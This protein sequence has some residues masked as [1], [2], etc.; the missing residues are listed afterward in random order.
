MLNAKYLLKP[1]IAMVILQMVLLPIAPVL[2]QELNSTTSTTINTTEP[3]PAPIAL[4]VITSTA[5]IA[6]VAIEPVSQV[7]STV[8]LP[9]DSTMTVLDTSTPSST[10]ERLAE[11]QPLLQ[12]T[13]TIST[14]APER[15]PDYS[16]VMRRLNHLDKSKDVSSSEFERFVQSEKDRLDKTDLD[17]S[18]KSKYFDLLDK[19]L[20]R[21]KNEPPT[22]LEKIV[23]KTKE[24]FGLDSTSTISN[25]EPF[26]IPTK[27]AEFKF[28]TDQ[29]Y[30][31]QF[32]GAVNEH[33]TPRLMDMFNQVFKL[34]QASA[35]SQYLPTINDVKADNEVVINSE[36]QDLAIALNNNPVKILNYVRQNIAYEPYF[37]A[38]KGSLGCLKEKVCN[39]VDAS[40]LTISLLRAADIPA[41]YKKSVV[42]MN[43]EQ[44]K[45]LLGV[46]DLKT[47]YMAWAMNKVP[48]YTLSTT[49]FSGKAENY[50]FSN[51]TSLGLEWVFV[52]AFYDYDERG[53]NVDNILSFTGATTTADVQ[54]VLQ[55]Y[56]KK[57][58]IPIDAV[59]KTYN[60]TKNEIVHDTASFDTQNF[61]N[62]F[63][64]HN[65]ALSPLQKYAQDLKNTTGKDILN[66]SY[67]STNVGSTDGF[68]I[69]PPTLPYYTHTGEVGGSLIQPIAWSSLPDNYRA[70]VKISLFKDNDKSVVFEHTFF[71]NEINN[72][73]INLAYEGATDAD[74]QAIESYGGIHA[75]PAA[76]VNIK[77]YVLAG[78][79]RYDTNNTIKIGDK[80][81]LH[82]DYLQNGI[83]TYSD[84]KFS[85]AGNSEGIAVSLSKVQ[86]DPNLDT[87]SKILLQGNSALASKY[88]QHL[89]ETGNTLQKALDYR[90]NM[91]FSR[92][93]VTQNRILSTVDGTPTTFDF[94]GLTIDASSN[95]NDWSNRGIFNN[96]RKDFRLLWGEDASYYEGQIFDDITGLEG[97]STVKGLQYAYA[98]PADYTVYSITKTNESVID[99]LTLTDN[100]KQN[101]HTAVQAGDTVVTPNKAITDGAWTGIF[102]VAL[103]DD[104]TGT[105]AIGEQTQMNGGATNTVLVASVYTDIFDLKS[106]IIYIVEKLNSEYLFQE[107]DGH[108]IQCNILNTLKDD[109][110]KNYGWSSQYGQPCYKETKQYGNVSHTFIIA[111]N[112]TRFEGPGYNSY[113]V[114]K[115][116]VITVLKNDKDK[117]NF[118]GLSNINLDS[119]FF[120]NQIAG[121]YSWFGHYNSWP[122]NKPVTAYYEP[123]NNGGKGHVV[124]GDILD[125][126]VDNSYSNEQTICSTGNQWCSKKNWILNILG[127]P[128]GNQK[129][130]SPYIIDW[131]IDTTGDYQDFAG[132]QIYIKYNDDTYYVPGKIDDYLNQNGGTGG[133]LGFPTNDPVWKNN[134]NKLKQNFEGSGI[135][136]N[137]NDNTVGEEYAADYY[138]DE[139]DTNNNFIKGR[140]L[141]QGLWEGG[142]ALVKGA[143][144]FGAT[145]AVAG[146][147]IDFVAGSHGGATI[148]AWTLIGASV[149]IMVAE[150]YNQGVDN[151]FTGINSQIKNEFKNSAC[152]AR[153]I[154]LAAKY[155][156]SAIT[157]FSGIKNLASKT[158]AELKGFSV[159][160]NIFRA[161]KD[162]ILPQLKNSVL[163]N[164]KVFDLLFKSKSVK[165]DS[166]ISSIDDNIRLEIS[167]KLKIKGSALTSDEI[168]EIVTKNFNS[169]NVASNIVELLDWKKLPNK[170]PNPLVDSQ[171]FLFSIE[172]GFKVTSAGA[173]TDG[174]GYKITNG[175][176]KVVIKD[177]KLYY[178]K[179]PNAMGSDYKHSQFVKGEPVDGAYMLST[180]NKGMLKKY[181]H[182]SGHYETPEDRVVLLEFFFKESKVNMDNAVKVGLDDPDIGDPNI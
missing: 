24:I 51:E 17:S 81:I 164:I 109:I 76:L 165:T 133:K 63:F 8:Q 65:G 107:G 4:P 129:P 14:P 84:E 113:W 158:P 37:G 52:E 23:N 10:P 125:K 32:Q 169:G 49:T 75:T 154:Y 115:E 36:I 141:L 177:G 180:D 138:C 111:T 150:V 130:A 13:S 69:L 87:N 20:K 2:A 178:G 58:W 92:A 53:A 71:G 159:A 146:S 148:A 54:N 95:I 137:L 86:V 72:A 62:G 157:V 128:T 34:D 132:G 28:N 19:Q 153:A 167:Q 102:Y 163:N 173:I 176:I 47:A 117:D 21:L 85:I 145:T 172:N 40:S 168:S 70:Q 66:V 89:E 41:R 44:I 64:Q 127:Y 78:Y 73:E 142:S 91:V 55:G 46:D 126:L 162:E 103:A 74:K 119:S 108:N 60:R 7:T 124:Y 166:V 134:S 39:D 83:Q 179:V 182:G 11:P 35:D 160:N 31:Q 97:I 161:S 106:K 93:V 94:K 143:I 152:E 135:L 105:Y 123:T 42:E 151:F 149:G 82:F 147:A 80:L 112:G 170:K 155:V 100:T 1:L 45:N 90:Y 68:Q 33:P 67:Q 26:R 175:I 120:F 131:G 118:G 30:I 139:I 9:L 27:P 99:T 114:T 5:P 6:P 101:M 43:A 121:T 144:I 174:R 122:Q 56:S 3:V 77:P 15:L 136:W 98:H 25:E 61:W 50:D 88:L 140:A 110:K 16:Q 171:P 59:V 104:G 79:A 48:V 116:Q 38:K 96:H 22:L 29:L 12:V 156:P 57:Q 18:N 181:N